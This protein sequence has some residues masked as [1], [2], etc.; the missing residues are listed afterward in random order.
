MTRSSKVAPKLFIG[1]QKLQVKNLN[2]QR[3]LMML[4]F[5]SAIFYLFIYIWIVVNRIRYPFELEWIEGSMVDQVQKLINGEMIYQ[6]PS[7]NFVPFNYPPLYFYISAGVSVLLGEGFFPLR[8]VS[9]AASLVSILSIFL[10][11]K[12]ETKNW[13]AATISTGLFIATYRITG[14]WL[15]IARVD[16]LYLALW[17]LFIYIIRGK[18]TIPFAV[19]T[20]VLA[21]LAILTKQTAI[22]TTF[23]V[24][25]ILA[26][27]RWKYAISMLA[28][29]GI[30]LG[31]TTFGLNQ[32]TDGWYSYYVFTLL[33]NQVWI[34]QAFISF[35]NEDLLIHLPIATLFAIIYFVNIYHKDRKGFFQWL[36]IFLGALIG[37]FVTRVRMGGY[38]NVLLPLFAVITILFG[39]GLNDLLV[40]KGLPLPKNGYWSAN[41][42]LV[43]CLIQFAV[44]LYNP[45]AQ[46]PSARDR[47]AGYEL[48]NLIS[49]VE[50]EVFLPDHG[51][52]SKMAGKMT[53][54]HNSEIWEV[55]RGN[56]SNVG[57]DF[58][59]KDLDDAIRLQKFDLIIFDTERNFCCENIKD[60][61]I[62]EGEVF[63]EED[64]FYPVTG[65]R[66][67][68]TYIYI[69]RRLVSN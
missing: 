24:I 7:I 47:E 3:M 60:Y 39:M 44:L 20:G 34:L 21:A 40:K 2:L 46:I 10:I 68:P 11:V 15:D 9:F 37:S 14:A 5:A 43:A 35:W 36:A 18:K 28:L 6:A 48:I 64:V 22:I 59:S 58:L 42:V 38:D 52:I 30:I 4:V 66:I 23:P 62:L 25:V 33:Q 13:W 53:Y 32:F 51:Y 45:L 19:L 8:M 54:A 29:I 1:E 61:Y 50:G 63:Q 16:S 69:A 17:L 65:W 55:L 57:K 67:R 56:Q 49:N 12:D 27:W 26:G 41:I 31:G